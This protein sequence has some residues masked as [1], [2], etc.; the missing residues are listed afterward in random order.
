VTLEETLLAEIRQLDQESR[1]AGG[2]RTQAEID[3]TYLLARLNDTQGWLHARTR[4]TAT[5]VGWQ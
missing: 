3:R 2:R 1:S 4:Y 5:G